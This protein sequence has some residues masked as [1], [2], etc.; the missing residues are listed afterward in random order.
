MTTCWLWGSWPTWPSSLTC[1]L[2]RTWPTV[3]GHLLWHVGYDDH[4]LP[5]HLLWHAGYEDHDLPGHL[6]WHVGYEGLGGLYHQF[7]A[8]G[9]RHTSQEENISYFEQAKL[10]STLFSL[11]KTLKNLKYCGKRCFYVQSAL[12][13]Y[14][15]V[16]PNVKVT[17]ISLHVIPIHDFVS[18]YSLCGKTK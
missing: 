6:L 11:I 13:K 17:H 10:N 12:K 1:W 9:G 14:F 2:W 18:Y 15:L 8:L 16:L 7:V 5:G 4:D 3:P